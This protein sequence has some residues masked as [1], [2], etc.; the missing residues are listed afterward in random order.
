[1]E[2]YKKEYKYLEPEDRIH[3]PLTIER[4][5]ENYAKC[6]GNDERYE[7]LWTTWAHNKKW[8]TRMLQLVC[9]SFQSYSMHDASHSEAVLHNIELILGENRGAVKKVP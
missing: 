6:R 1:M 7:T 5:L 2:N 9:Q 8:L 3:I 4:H